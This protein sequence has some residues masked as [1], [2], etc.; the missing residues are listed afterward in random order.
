MHLLPVMSE[1]QVHGPWNIKNQV[2]SLIQTSFGKVLYAEPPVYSLDAPLVPL[3][4][5]SCCSGA[6]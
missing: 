6:A 3:S 4:I 5:S 1:L 2:K